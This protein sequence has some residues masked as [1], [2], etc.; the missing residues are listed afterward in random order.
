[1]ENKAK[2]RKVRKGTHSCEEC[3]RR[4]VKCIFAPPEDAVCITC[5]RRGA[6]CTSQ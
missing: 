2:R 6:K 3:R 4:K 1:D 5:Q